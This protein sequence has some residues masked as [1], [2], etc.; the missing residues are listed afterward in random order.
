MSTKLVFLCAVLIAAV[1]FVEAKP[2][3]FQVECDVCLGGV[4]LIDRLIAANF[5]LAEMEKP[6]TEYCTKFVFPH[7]EHPMCPG[8]IAAYA[9]SVVYVIEHTLMLPHEV[10]NFLNV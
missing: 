6:F 3:K 10:C 2:S 8:I 4:Y 9:P 7:T 5:T 1:C